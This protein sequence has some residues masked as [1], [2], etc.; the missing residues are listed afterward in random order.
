LKS[1]QNL[2]SKL[3]LN[4]RIQSKLKKKIKRNKKETKKK[5]R[6]RKGKGKGKNRKRKIRDYWA[7]PV[8]EV[9]ADGL[10]GA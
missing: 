9:K 10:C 3:I 1:E 5:K 2:K 4:F 8:K 7:W 6:N